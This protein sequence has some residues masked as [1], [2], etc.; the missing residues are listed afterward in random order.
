MGFYDALIIAA[1]L[2]GIWLVVR[3]LRKNKGCP[4]C[5]DDCAGCGKK[6]KRKQP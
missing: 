2:C 1:V 3:Y 5:K 6:E 4:G